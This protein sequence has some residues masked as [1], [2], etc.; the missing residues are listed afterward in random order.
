MK[1]GSLYT[2][3]ARFAQRA[4]TTTKTLLT[5][6]RDLAFSTELTLESDPAVGTGVLVNNADWLDTLRVKWDVGGT[7]PSYTFSVVAYPVR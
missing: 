5:V 6:K 1:I 4:A 2:N 3:L 7:T